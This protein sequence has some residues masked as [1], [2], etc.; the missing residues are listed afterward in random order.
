VIFITVGHQMPF[1]RLVTAM[2]AW[3]HAQHRSDVFAQIGETTSW[4]R[5]IQAVP[6]LTPAQF[7]T[8]MNEATCIVGH[9]GTG[10]II[11][12]LQRGT[13]LLVVPRK[14]SLAE[15]RNDH[16]FA[17][18]DF[19]EREGYVLV[20]RELDQLHAKLDMLPD[21]TPRSL[22]RAGADPRLIRRL[23]H[24]AFDGARDALPTVSQPSDEESCA[25]TG[26]TSASSR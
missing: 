5:Y 23:R 1:D 22:D 20:A 6:F 14:S 2:D 25:M 9:A 15:T 8:R 21:F 11:A 24:F 19:F 26:A 10:T 16:Q 18:A 17:T 4:P 3:A 13:P 12:A 7:T